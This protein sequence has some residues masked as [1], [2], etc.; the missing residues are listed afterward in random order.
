MLEERRIFIATNDQIRKGYKKLIKGNYNA[1]R[2]RDL[3]RN[4]KIQGHHYELPNH[5][6]TFTKGTEPALFVGHVGFTL[7]TI[8]ELSNAL[9]WAKSVNTVE[10]Q[11]LVQTSIENIQSN[12]PY[13]VQR[14][15]PL[16]D[17]ENLLMWQ[18][19]WS[20]RI[21]IVDPYGTKEG[22]NLKGMLRFLDFIEREAK[23]LTHLRFVLGS[24]YT[25]MCDDNGNPISPWGE[26][27]RSKYKQ[28][29]LGIMNDHP[30]FS[31]L[32]LIQIG[33]QKGSNRYVSFGNHNQEITY[34]LQK[35]LSG[36]FFTKE[37]ND[38]IITPLT[39]NKPHSQTVSAGL[40][41]YEYETLNLTKN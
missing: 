36:Y 24:N 38:F 35:G 21:T 9:H 15:N 19:R 4:A 5:L 40:V 3:L 8:L 22:D 17:I 30:L 26:K 32:E 37:T 2:M 23:G 7:I 16:A 6:P 31:R 39:L 13:I 12:Y 14:G 28:N 20:K 41:E 10:N 25:G 18:V 33:F 27:A 11:R 34:E 29:L 1:K